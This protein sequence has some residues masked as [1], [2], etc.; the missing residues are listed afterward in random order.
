VRVPRFARTIPF[1]TP[2]T[3][4]VVFGCALALLVCIAPEKAF[5]QTGS[6][7]CPL[8]IPGT[9]ASA[10]GLARQSLLIPRTKA[11]T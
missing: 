8:D 7:Y 1:S 2:L 10:S 3:I 4:L 9:A 11:F 5:A 6:V